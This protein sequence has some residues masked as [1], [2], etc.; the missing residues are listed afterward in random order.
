[1]NDR[2]KKDYYRMTGEKYKNGIKSFVTMRFSHQ[3]KPR[4]E[5]AKKS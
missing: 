3:I 5:I 1:M 4:N 2:W